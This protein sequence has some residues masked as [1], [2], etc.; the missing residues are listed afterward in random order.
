MKQIIL[1]I[2]LLVLAALVLGQPLWPPEWSSLA[3]QNS[4]G[5]VDTNSAKFAAYRIFNSWKLKSERI[6]IQFF[7]EPLLVQIHQSNYQYSFYP[8]NSTCGVVDLGFGPLPP[9]W[10]TNATFEGV[11]NVNGVVCNTWKFSTSTYWEST[12]DRSPVKVDE[13]DFFVWNFI[14]GTFRAGPQSASLFI[15]PSYCKK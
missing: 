6:E 11:Q 12:E 15:P 8:H 2:V 13:S 3:Y 10:L 14:P 9:T 4:G 7:N 5:F 1:A